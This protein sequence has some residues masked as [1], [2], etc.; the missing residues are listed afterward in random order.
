MTPLLK[1]NEQFASS[2]TPVPLAPP[3]AQ[4]VV[5]TCVDHR[6]DPEPMLGIQPG[7]ALVFRNAG[8]RVNQSVIE[9][10]AYLAYLVGL[11]SGGAEPPETLFEVAVIHH[12]QCGTGLLGDPDFKR[13]VA[14]ATGVSEAALEATAVP[15]PEVTVK[16][17]VE[18]LLASPL[19]ASNISISGHIYDITTGRI[20]TLLEARHPQPADQA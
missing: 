4:V 17:D 14:A 9:E 1:N 10:I 19:I 6:I 20:S 11:L 12:N 3:A 18:R 5:L 7:D 13:K 16:T 8:G 15:D 2:Y